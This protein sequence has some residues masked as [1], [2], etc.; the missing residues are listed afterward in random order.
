[1]AAVRRGT[2]SASPS[3]AHAA[4]MATDGAGAWKERQGQIGVLLQ[5]WLVW[6]IDPCQAIL[7]LVQAPWSQVSALPYSYTKYEV[8]KCTMGHNCNM[9]AMHGQE[10]SRQCSVCGQFEGGFEGGLGPGK[11]GEGCEGIRGEGRETE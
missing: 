8:Y 9:F 11:G 10:Q 3:S 1:M 4:D 7:G 2:P 5:L 6:S